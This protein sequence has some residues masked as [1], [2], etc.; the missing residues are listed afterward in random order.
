MS[1]AF[2]LCI[3]RL[4]AVG[5]ICQASAVVTRI[6]KHRP[7]IKITWI[8]GKHEHLLL[9]GM[10]DVEFIVY[11]K[12]A[13]KAAKRHLE[14]ALASR[15]F[16][17]LFMM[18]ATLQASLLSK[19]IKAKRR[20]GFDWKRSKQSHWLFAKEHIEAKP[21]AHVLDG[22][23]GFA[24]KLDIPT[25]NSP[26]WDIPVS[27]SDWQWAK[28]HTSSLGKYAVINPAAS[29]PTRNWTIHGYIA[30]AQHLIDKGFKI[31]LCGE[32]NPANQ[33]FYDEILKTNNIIS[34]NLVG[35]A[36]LKQTVAV[37]AGAELL[38]APDT[39]EVHMATAVGTLVVGLYAHSNFRHTGPYLSQDYTASIYEINV[40]GQKGKEWVY[41]PW[42]TKAKG[43]DLM[44]HL[45][46][47]T[48]LKKVDL[49]L[50]HLDT[51][52]ST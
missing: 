5:D 28:N 29:K 27:Q 34:L 47:K 50:R 26:S 22:F 44:T 40:K 1:Q 24:D 36:S 19:K 21:Y 7:D 46:V 37:L 48:V 8:I 41:L 18:Q 2:Q 25:D 39:E 31:V 45:L 43:K 10:M 14:K 11:D 30:V 49:A 42:G 33:A 12:K 38:I 16:D 9:E 3:L 17:A 52:D 4:S 23:M 6:R 13:G 35:Q 20:I 32:F 51:V 15:V